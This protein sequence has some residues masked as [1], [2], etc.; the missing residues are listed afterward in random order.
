MNYAIF[1]NTA[2]AIR[3]EARESAE[4]VTQL[5]FGEY[6]EIID[7]QNSFAKIKNRIDG[8]EGWA[9]QK[10]LTE[11]S[12]DTYNRLMSQPVFRTNVPVADVF[13]LTDK[14]IYRLSAG[15]ILPFYQHEASGF[16]IAQR[17]YQIHPSF[18]TYL[19]NS[20][21][22]NI[23]AAAM[24]FQNAPYLWGGKTIMGIDCSGLVQSVFNMNGVNLPRDASMQVHEGQTIDTLE[25]AM[26][27][28]LLF[29]EKNG[30][31]THVG[32]Y[33]G[34]CK[35]IHASGKVRIDKVDEKGVYN[36]D[37]E[38]YTH[39]LASIKRI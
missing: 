21:K 10:M 34:D 11:I 1:L 4:M 29:F 19:P 39:Q 33:M 13:C 16:E 9:D 15:S 28:D 20:Y 32:I 2:L 35:I 18:V 17:K 26:P 38:S 37:T 12:E 8:Y 24:L 3:A 5:I 27:S 23:L 25:N 36:I 30:R 31:I 6:V 14:S 7:S 22:D